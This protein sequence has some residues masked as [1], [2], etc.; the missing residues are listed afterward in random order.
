MYW[1]AAPLAAALVYGIVSLM[2]SCAPSP[3]SSASLRAFDT[4]PCRGSMLQ[5]LNGLEHR[6]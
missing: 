4:E 6:S 2:P 1:I 5:Y 3:P